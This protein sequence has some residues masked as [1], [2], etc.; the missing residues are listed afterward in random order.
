MRR[1]VTVLRYLDLAG[2][3][4]SPSSVVSTLERLMEHP[5]PA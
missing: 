1:L 3:N 4:E 5:E 2:T